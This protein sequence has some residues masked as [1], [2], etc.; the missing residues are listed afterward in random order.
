MKHSLRFEFFKKRI[1]IYRKNP[2]LFAEEVLNFHPD[3]WQAKALMDLA[4]NPKVAI[5]SGQGVGKTGIEAV[6]LLWFL[7]CFPYPR[8]V[9]TAPTKQQLHDVLWSEV[10][11]W[12]SKSPLLSSILKWTKTYIYMLGY[13]K[14]WFA[15]ARTA[16][17]PENMQGFHEDNM[18]F[19]VDE[20]SGVADP[21]MEA[22]L[23]TLS[24]TNNKLLMCAN[25]TKRSGVFFDAFNKDR[26][27]YCCY[28]VSSADS[29]RTNKDNIKSLIRKY[30]ENSNVVRVRVYGEFPND[31]D[32]VFFSISEIHKS[33][34]TEISKDTEMALGLNG[35]IKTPDQIHSVDVGCDVA[36]FG[37]DKTV[38]TYKINELCM[39]YKKINGKDTTWTAGN[40][41]NLYKYI[42]TVLKYEGPVPIKIDNG[43]IGGG[44]IDQLM[45]IK[46]TSSFYDDMLIYPINF[47]QP[48]RHL[49]YYD[50][51]TI[52]L[53]M[54]KDLITPYDSEGNELP[55][56][57]IL[58][59]DDDLIGEFTTRK[60]D[61]V[62]GGR[63]K[64]ESKKEMKS[65]GLPSPDIVD[66]IAL[67]CWP[68]KI[69]KKK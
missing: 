38:I 14:R 42:K 15:V 8:V 52:M 56:R 47:G 31:E 1:P 34:N 57:L 32:D 50:T 3:E 63:Q 43:G 4:R 22:I 19:I 39:I 58:P 55:S 53:G 24:G 48:K 60:Y 17:K 64:V 40:L 51:T 37:D 2:V 41:V 26:E 67:C 33:L 28:T 49:F 36:R 9:A 66:S 29:T 12:L 23:G 10:S 7:C 5:K 59:K 11:K 61:F 13:E 46:K 27:L 69:R 62:T 25:P 35:Y 44:V 16:T 21:I 30:G 18:L 20:A 45:A 54:I 68:V 6:A 65:R